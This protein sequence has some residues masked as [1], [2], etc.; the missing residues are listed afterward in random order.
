MAGSLAIF[1]SLFDPF[2]AAKSFVIFTGAV[3]LVGY[4]LLDLF[5][6]RFKE[7]I[8]AQR[9]FLYLLFGFVCLFLIRT[10]TT[11]DVNG[12]LFGV[13][14][15]HSGFITYFGYALILLL[16]SLYVNTR[17]FEILVRG[18]LIAGFL[19][20]LYLLLEFIGIEFWNMSKVYEGTSG[21]FGNPNFSGAFMSLTAIASFWFLCN[22]TTLLIKYI[23][24]ITFPLALF[25]IYTSK[26]LQGY[27]SLA[28]GISLITFMIL[29]KFKKRYGYFSIIIIS[30][31]GFASLL[32]SLQIG[33][34]SSLLY[35][36]SVSERGD[37]WRTAIAMIKDNPL[38]GVGIERYG[39]YFRQYR[40][41]K[42]ALRSGPDVFSD[43]AHN[44]VLHLMATGGIFLG[45]IYL[46]ITVGILAV[47]IKALLTSNGIKQQALTAVL[48][49]WIPIQAQNAISVDNPGV[50]VWSWI[51]GGAVI[52]IATEEVAIDEKKLKVKATKA[53]SS[54]SEVHPL[55]P[56]IALVCVLVAIGGTVKPLIAQKSFAFA[57]HLGIDSNIPETLSNKVAALINAEDQ[58]PGNVT[59][60]RLSSNS[61]FIDKAWQETIDAAERA[62][63]KDPEDWVSWWFMASAYEQSGDR[64]KAIPARKKTV[65]LDPWNTSVLLELAKDQ[66]AASDV[67]GFEESKRKILEINPNGLDAQTVSGL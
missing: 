40:D 34:L 10:L 60:P 51:L 45:T 4:A 48:A 55:A 13:V 2:A 36:G 67:I 46:L 5:K 33:P 9:L 42:Q 16:S 38:W 26:A 47:G 53:P 15:R 31:G 64:V 22:K 27:I 17:N 39:F 8:T 29:W 30:L 25:G 28:I 37:M 62:I 58:D 11:S 14:G 61:L 49:L 63:S 20:G 24:I 12:A 6:A 18:L 21:L 57:F 56:V 43:N 50:F 59:L 66:L 54:A 65:E 41:L 52:G 19:A 1:T 35:K 23:S 44:V 7:A 3:L 32:G